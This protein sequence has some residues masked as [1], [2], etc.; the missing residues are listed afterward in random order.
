MRLTPSVIAVAAAGLLVL[1]GSIVFTS[2]DRSTI[3]STSSSSENE[4]QATH[5]AQQP[6]PARGALPDVTTAPSGA[7]EVVPK[8]ARWEEDFHA[9]SDLGQFVVDAAAAARGDCALVVSMVRKGNDEAGYL[10]LVTQRFTLPEDTARQKAEYRRCA[11]LGQRPGFAAWSQ[12][13]G[14]LMTGGYWRELAAQRTPHL[15]ASGTS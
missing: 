10:A 15:A 2:L 3:R 1:V 4:V 6:A 9:A 7:A 13:T 14:G 12:G 8:A 11:S 5:E